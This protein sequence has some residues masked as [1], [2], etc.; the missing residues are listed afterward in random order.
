MKCFIENEDNFLYSI[1]VLD[2]AECKELQGYTI[3]PL[4]DFS[5]EYYLDPIDVGYAFSWG[6]GV[7]TLFW[8][9]GYVYS[10]AKSS[11]IHSVK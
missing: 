1:E 9:I 11:L 8:F 5:V 6:F 4:N 3:I 10:V 7:I 2:L